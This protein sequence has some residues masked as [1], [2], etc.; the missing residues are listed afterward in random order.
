MQPV[1]AAE[2]RD[3]TNPD[4]TEEDIDL[5]ARLIT[6]EQGY[7]T[8]YGGATG[9][10]IIEDYY[11][12]GS[13]VLNR[14]NSP[15]FPDTLRDVIYQCGQYDVVNNGAIERDYDDIAWEVAE[16]L[17]TY[18]ADIPD[19]V[20]FQ[21]EFTQGSGVYKQSGRTYYCYR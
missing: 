14:M 9:S 2:I 16:E 6:A 1:A 10:R 18:G 3:D 15:E 8:S 5:L 20:V 7:A 12:T 11:L 13:V 19:N 21:A 4:I 17:L